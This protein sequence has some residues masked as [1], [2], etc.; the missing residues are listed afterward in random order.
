MVKKGWCRTYVNA[1]VDRL[2]R[3]FRWAAEEETLPVTIY[4]ALRAVES[5]RRGR[6]D[7]RETPKV[8][9]AAPE[10]VEAVLPF[11]PPMVRAMVGFQRLTGCRPDEVC[12]VRPID[13]DM[14]N[15][16]CWVYRPGSDQGQV[17]QHKT[18]HHGHERLVLIGPK[19]QEALRPY[20]GTRLEAYC[21][22]P[23]ESERRR[24][25]MRRAARQT[26]L[27][28]SQRARR[29]KAR[30]KRAPRDHYDETSY[31]NA[32][33]R[34]CDRAFPLSE[35]LAPRQLDKG[36]REGRTAWWTRLTQEEKAEVRAWRKQRRWHPNQLRHSRAT[37]LRPYGLD[38]TKTVLGHSKVETTQIYAEKDLA[39]AME[40]MAKIG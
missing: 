28:P 16:A 38:L 31:R 13:I 8:R 34:A 24:G 30:R 27:T 14:G 22:S 32:V 40:L 19:A 37:E 2:R 20:L 21:F 39:A 15:P 25:E 1:Q 3:M 12:R 36:K 29:P 9:P 10:R 6:T 11:L 23:A 17:G 5:L 26:P 4:Q 35:P 33:Y 18:A 7:A